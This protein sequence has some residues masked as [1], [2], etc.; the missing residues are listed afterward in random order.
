M[1]VEMLPSESH[2]FYVDF[3][4]R[5]VENRE[6]TIKQ[7]MPVFKD[8]EY[9]IITMPGGGLVVDKLIDD[10]LINEWKHGEGR[11]PPSPFAMHANA[12]TLRKLGMGSVALKDKA[13]AYLGSAQSN[14]AS[15]EIVAMKLE[16]KELTALVEKQSKQLSKP[17]KRK[18]A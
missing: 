15:E 3:E 2:G 1:S 5:P 6:E 10:R 17:P 9:A 12:D 14:K 11:K 7:G 13:I 18:K 4:L 16:I 8:V